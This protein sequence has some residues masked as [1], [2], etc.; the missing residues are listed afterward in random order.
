MKITSNPKEYI[1]SPSTNNIQNFIHTLESDYSDYLSKN[2][3]V[4]FSLFTPTVQEVESLQNL[5]DQHIA[6]QKSFVIVVQ[7]FDFNDATEG[8]NIVPTLQEAYDVIEIDDIQ[9]DL[10]F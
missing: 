9:R 6:N 5:H 10:G 8:L 2:I 1:L 7:D 4:D 3:I